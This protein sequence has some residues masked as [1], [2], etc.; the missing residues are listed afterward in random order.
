MSVNSIIE[1][2]LSQIVQNIWPLVCTS[3]K[4]PN[5]YIVYNP[6]LD[7]PDDFGDG[8]A[9]EW[10]LYIQVHYFTKSNYFEKRK[11][12]RKSLLEAGF[13]LEEITTTY[14]KDSGYYHL[15]FSCNIEEKMEE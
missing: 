3:E 11:K 14:E 4:P 1:T 6:E 2:A 15:C 10:I 5:E 12:I 7:K 9:N 8:E 13:L